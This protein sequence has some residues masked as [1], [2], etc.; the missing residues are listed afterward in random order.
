MIP[1]VYHLP[2]KADTLRNTLHVLKHLS[3]LKM[4][5]IRGRNMYEH[6]DYVLCS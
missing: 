6:H 2:F 1:H 5:A 4:A 3:S